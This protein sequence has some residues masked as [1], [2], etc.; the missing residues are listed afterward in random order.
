MDLTPFFFHAKYPK[1]TNNHMDS[2]EN[3]PLGRDCH[4]VQEAWQ[5][6]GY[7]VLIGGEMAST[8]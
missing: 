5:E 4:Q 3:H 2:I 8:S 7:A 1:A 6:I